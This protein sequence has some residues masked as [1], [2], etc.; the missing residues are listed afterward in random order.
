[1]AETAKNGWTKWI[2]GLLWGVIVLILTTTIGYVITN[3]ELCAES[4]VEVVEKIHEEKDK[5]LVVVEKKIDK[6]TKK[7]ESMQTEQRTMSNNQVR[8]MTILKRIDN[9]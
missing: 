1:M 5:V 4:K 3:R 7:I 9:K 8:M 6:V 2:A